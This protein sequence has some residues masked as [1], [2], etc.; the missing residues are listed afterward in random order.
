MNS[1]YDIDDT[2]SDSN[3]SDDQL[4]K[5]GN[6][7]EYFDSP[8]HSLFFTLEFLTQA[9]KYNS[10]FSLQKVE[11]RVRKKLTILIISF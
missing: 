7:Y 2:D 11:I 9:V 1:L 10:L 3:E 5:E 4:K 8:S 6:R